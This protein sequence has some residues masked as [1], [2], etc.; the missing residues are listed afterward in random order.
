MCFSLAWLENVLIWAVVV[1]VVVVLLRLVIGAALPHLG[2][3]GDA[4]VF[5]ARIVSIVVWA[6]VVIAIIM[7]V[8]DLISCLLPAARLR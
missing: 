5:A 8:F 1:I 6:V 2:F 7:F 4:L 3:A